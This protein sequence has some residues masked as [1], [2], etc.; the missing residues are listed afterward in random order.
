MDLFL[1]QDHDKEIK[2]YISDIVSEI[3]IK[4]QLN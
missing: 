2:K 4:N 1:L 3:E